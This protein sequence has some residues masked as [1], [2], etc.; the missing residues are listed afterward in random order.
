VSADG[1]GIRAVFF[2]V[3]G[4]LVRPWGFR[5]LLIREHGITPEQTA[6][7]FRGPF[8][9]CVEGRADL[10]EILPPWLLEWGWKGDVASFVDAW[11]SVEND[12][13]EAV[14]EIAARVRA[15]GLRCFAASTQE[16]HRAAYLANEM[17]FAGRFER[18]LFS[19]DVGVRKPH[20]EFFREVARRVGLPPG[21]LLL[22]DDTP[23]NV[24]GARHAGWQAEA[25]TTADAL[26]RSLQ[27]LGVL[28]GVPPEG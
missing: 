4:V 7:F 2:D 12:P 16:R 21:A 13:D 15:A 3:D 18:L 11:F 19:C 23:A 22:I 9:E 5:D 26:V 14:L 28:E 1:Q 8:L 17:G 25:F 20:V 10:R 27:G 6:P 24:Q